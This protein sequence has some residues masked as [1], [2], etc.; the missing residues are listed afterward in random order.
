[1][2]VTLRFNTKRITTDVWK[3][4][5]KFLNYW[6]LIWIY[7]KVEIPRPF[8]PY[9]SPK[10]FFGY[11]TYAIKVRAAEKRK[12]TLYF[13]FDKFDDIGPP[14]VFSSREREM[15][16]KGHKILW[17]CPQCNKVK[18]INT[19][20]AE[21]YDTGFTG[22]FYK[23]YNKP[24]TYTICDCEQVRNHM[25]TY[26]TKMPIKKLVEGDYCNF[27]YFLSAIESQDQLFCY[28]SYFWRRTL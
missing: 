28:G 21:G 26:M 19:V 9:V 17:E 12:L 2:A 11:P 3:E 14:D 6:E 8:N 23:V 16:L 1:M 13:R 15:K 25:N 20:W 27:H 5:A 10:Y 24:Y 18:I 4:I 7:R 22:L